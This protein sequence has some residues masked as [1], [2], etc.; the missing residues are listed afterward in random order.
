MSVTGSKPEGEMCR[1]SIERPFNV[2]L[3]KTLLVPTNDKAW[4][5]FA[6]VMSEGSQSLLQAIRMVGLERTGWSAEDAFNVLNARYLEP[7]RQALATYE[8][9][10]DVP[11]ES[12]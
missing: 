12:R 6:P 9:T 5:A 11:K 1:Y 7:T 2:E 3:W 10:G 4:R 8:R